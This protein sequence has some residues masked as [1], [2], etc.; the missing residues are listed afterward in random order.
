MATARTIVPTASHPVS[1]AYRKAHKSYVLASGLLA[2]WE[3]LGITLNTKEKWGIELKSPTAVPLILFTLV[4]YSGYKMWIEWLQCDREA[5][6]NRAARLDFL[7]AHL[8]AASAIIISIVQYLWRIQ[9]VNVIETKVAPQN[10][11]VVGLT[12]TFVALGG[13]VFLRWWRFTQWA[14]VVFTSVAVVR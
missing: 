2:A 14:K 8:I 5:Q 10:R 13:W 6:N 4:S 9:I 3:L 12:M 7:I 11:V 1:D